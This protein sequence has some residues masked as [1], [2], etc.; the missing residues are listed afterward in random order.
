MTAVTTL[1]L[2][3][4]H[5]L[6]LSVVLKVTAT[7]LLALAAA[8][9]AHR[10]RAA[11]RHVLLAA[12]F[13]VLAVLPVAAL[14]APAIR[15][16]VAVA[17]AQP[18]VPLDAAVVT[19]APES[20][21]P[22]TAS[23]EVATGPA[24]AMSPTAMLM[25]VWILGAAMCLVP[26][27]IGLWQVST[28]R[29]SALPWTSGRA[30]VD[31]LTRDAGIHRRVDVLLHESAP[32]PM[33]FGLLR[34]TIVLPLDARRWTDEDLVRAV[35]HELEHVRRGDWATQCLARVACAFYWFHPLVWISRQQLALEAERACD[36][37]V[38]SRS[39]ATVYADQLVDL[40]ERLTIARHQPLLA[41]A[42]RSDPR[43]A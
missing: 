36:D 24:F 40:A 18:P 4:S 39:D 23:S 16:P 25:A 6:L 17:M 7:T 9:L 33:T 42:N 29:R 20:P 43:R 31:Q 21:A 38:L 22:V 12:S 2:A 1:M 11:F 13:A 19:N 26:V 14:V 30:L 5:S 3:A 32:G 15:V 27:L 28:L 35:V 34:A 10:S 8:K 37:A 41:M